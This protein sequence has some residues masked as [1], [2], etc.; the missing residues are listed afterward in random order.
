MATFSYV[1][2]DSAG[3]KVEGKVAAATAQAVLAELQARQ[4]APVT[5][6]ELRESPRAARRIRLRHVAMAYR[7]LSDLLRAGVP[8]LRALRLLGRSKAY[9]RL[10]KVLAEVADAVAEGSRLADAMAAHGDVFPPIQIAMVRAGER[11]GF[12]EP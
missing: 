3:Q 4:L 2:R 5:V 10:A 8:L 12:L 1:A 9:P 11:G 7:Q 6:Q